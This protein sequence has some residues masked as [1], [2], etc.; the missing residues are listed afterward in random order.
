MTNPPVVTNVLYHKFYTRN[1]LSSTKTVKEWKYIKIKEDMNLHYF[2]LP[3]EK[4]NCLNRSRV[5]CRRQCDTFISET[6]L[7]SKWTVESL[8]MSIFV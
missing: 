1:T 6:R 8:K 7:P 5:Y 4:K 2:Y 3:H